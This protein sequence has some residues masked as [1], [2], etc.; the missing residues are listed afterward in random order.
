MKRRPRTDCFSGE[1]VQALLAVERNMLGP[2][3]T[4]PET[5][6]DGSDPVYRTAKKDGAEGMNVTP[7]TLTA[8]RPARRPPADPR[9]LSIVIPTVGRRPWCSTVSGRYGRSGVP[10]GVELIVVDAGRRRRWTPRPSAIVAERPRASLPH[11]EHGRFNGTKGC[12]RRAG[13][14]F[15]F[16]MTTPMFKPA[17]GPRWWRVMRTRTWAS[18][19]ARSGATRTRA[20]PDGRGATSSAGHS[21]PGYAPRLR[22]AARGGLACRG[23][24]GVSP[25][26]HDG[27]R[28]AGRKFTASMMKTLIRPGGCAAPAGGFGISRSGGLPLLSQ[29]PPGA[30]HKQSMFR[31]GR[32]RALLMRGTTAGLRACPVLLTAPAV[33]G[34]K[35]VALAARAG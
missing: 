3:S 14:L 31:A 17:G 16:S 18:W 23:E 1:P 5:R 22:R 20:S 7:S 15:I 35:A 12:A 25:A 24:H 9:L 21:G 30:A 6:L 4:S 33:Q 29:T 10:E 11:Q 8:P 19:P 26:G 27:H 28:R 34:F 2:D 32:N 13:S